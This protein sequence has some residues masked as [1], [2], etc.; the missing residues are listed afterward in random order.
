M[1]IIR[2]SGMEPWSSCCHGMITNGATPAALSILLNTSRSKGCNPVLGL[3]GRTETA[4]AQYC[5]LAVLGPHLYPM[6]KLL[7]SDLDLEGKRVFMRVDF[8]VPVDA[9]GAVTDDTRIRAALPTIQY[10]L[11]HGARLLLASHRGRPKGKPDPKYSLA[12][13]ARRLSALLGREVK[14]A[15]DCVGPAVKDMASAVAEGEA[16][17]LENL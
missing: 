4:S 13:A 6:S 9:L 15:P 17:M 8:N 11:E 2:T 16:L 1:R 12:P 3:N 10:A 5:V 14:L 7:I